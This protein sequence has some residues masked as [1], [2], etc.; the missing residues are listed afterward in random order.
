LFKLTFGIFG[1][2]TVF[3]GPKV[4]LTMDAATNSLLGA[5]GTLAIEVSCQAGPAIG[6]HCDILPKKYLYEAV[7]KANDRFFAGKFQPY[8]NE[9]RL[10][11]LDKKIL[12][13]TLG[14][15]SVTV[16]T[17][18]G[19][20][21]SMKVSGPSIKMHPALKSMIDG[22]IQKIKDGIRKLLDFLN[23]AWKVVK[24]AYVDA[25]WEYS[26]WGGGMF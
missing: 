1:Q 18:K 8:Q 22:W 21:F 19:F 11:A 14:S 15:V 12:I 7:E 9:L 25:G 2:I 26:A 24:E 20:S 10:T 17:A 3:G 6:F 16:D 4:T 5:S 23:E 13:V